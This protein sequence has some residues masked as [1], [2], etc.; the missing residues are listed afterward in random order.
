MNSN[1]SFKK[2]QWK[3]VIALALCLTMLVPSSSVFAAGKSSTPKMEVYVGTKASTSGNA[4]SIYY[5]G[6]AEDDYTYDYVYT[7]KAIK[8]SV[9]VYVSNS[10]NTTYKKASSSEYTVKYGSFNKNGKFKAAATKN[11]GVYY[12]QITFKGKYKNVNTQYV[13]YRIIPGKVTLNKVTANGKK[14]T[15]KWSKLAKSS[16]GRYE[17]GYTA[18]KS[19]ANDQRISNRYY[20]VKDV[21]NSAS[22]T[23]IKNSLSHAAKTYVRVRAYKE[24]KYYT[25]YGYSSTDILYGDWSK[26]KSVKLK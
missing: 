11:V 15:V 4:D 1:F 9:G 19:F 13:E 21:K 12:A 8:P 18:N 5:Y 6:Y 2:L 25:P 24:V 10:K 22:S 16:V 3:K 14:A 20:D 23:T 17:V 26:V 7:G